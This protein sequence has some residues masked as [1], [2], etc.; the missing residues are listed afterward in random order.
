MRHYSGRNPNQSSAM[1][2][3]MVAVK[4]LG[5]LTAIYVVLA[6]CAHFVSSG[7]IFPR[8]PVGYALG[9]EYLTLTAP[10]GTKLAARHWA[11]PTAKYTLIYL[12]G[13][14]QELGGLAEYMPTFV[15]AGYAVFAFD[16]RGY[17]LSEGESTEA[18]LYA[19]TQLAYDYVR[20]RLGVSPERIIIYGY[21]L[22]GG[23]AI[24]L[25]RKQPVAGLVIQGAFVSAYRVMTNIPL[26]PGDKFRNLAK[27]REVR[28]PVM[29]IHGTEDGT[30]PFWHGER[31]F[32]AIRSRKASLFITGGHHGGL[33]E[34]A[35]ARYWDELK[36]F[37]DGL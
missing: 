21:S 25:T 6:V 2:T 35:G 10:D 8:P 5:A 12:H 3:V 15:K 20:T 29:V 9:P 27:I 1:E 16:Y 11:N 30:V 17:G 26:F 14:Y 33:A 19:D 32:E 18:S 13:N 36:R 37:T 22:G 4:V 28:C 23:P 31:L 34:F 7:M 24:E